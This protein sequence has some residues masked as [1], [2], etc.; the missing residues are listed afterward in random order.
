MGICLGL[1]LLFENSE[2]FGYA[3]QGLGI[4][5]GTVKKFNFK[6]E[7]IY[8]PQIDGIKYL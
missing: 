3:K 6:N 4:I 2:E 5:K 8:I 1:Q 7:K